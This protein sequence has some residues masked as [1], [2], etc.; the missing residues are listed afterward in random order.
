MG[1]LTYS[2]Q[3]TNICESKQTLRSSFFFHAI[4]HT[5][6]FCKKKKKI[7][8]P[9]HQEEPCQCP[10]SVQ[11]QVSGLTGPLQKEARTVQVGQK[12]F[13]NWKNMKK[14]R[15]PWIKMNILLLKHM[16]RNLVAH[17]IWIDENCALILANSRK[18]QIRK[19]CSNSL[20]RKPLKHRFGN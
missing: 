7:H 12:W 17:S 13:M 15:K 4:F 8:V 14:H 20:I 9:L 16:N 1:I 10:G 3:K 2:N 11:G 19:T 18:H 5:F 6:F